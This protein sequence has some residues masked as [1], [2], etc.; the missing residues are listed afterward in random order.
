MPRGSKPLMGQQEKERPILDDVV[1]IPLQNLS[2]PAPLLPVPVAFPEVQFEDCSGVLNSELLCHHMHEMKASKS[3]GDG[4]LDAPPFPTSTAESDDVTFVSMTNGKRKGRKDSAQGLKRTKMDDDEVLKLPSTIC[5]FEMLFPSNTGSEA[6]KI[7]KKAKSGQAL[8]TAFTGVQIEAVP[9]REEDSL[10]QKYLQLCTAGDEVA[11]SLP[12]VDT[13]KVPFDREPHRFTNGRWLESM[14]VLCGGI[15]GTN[16][17]YVLEVSAEVRV[18]SG[19]EGKST[20]SGDRLLLELHLSLDLKLSMLR[21]TA[22]ASPP[23]LAD[24]LHRLLRFCYPNDEDERQIRSHDDLTASLIYSLLPCSRLPV[25]D[26]LQPSQLSPSLFP[27]QKRSVNFLLGREGKKITGQ[28]EDGESI[29]EALDGIMTHVGSQQLGLWWQRIE[30]GLF[31]NPLLGK[32]TRHAKETQLDQIQ[33]GILAEEMGLGKT[34]EVLALI[35]LNRDENRSTLP[36]HYDIEHELDISPTKTTLIVAPETLRQQWL[37]EIAL[38]APDLRTFSYLGHAEASKMVPQGM[39]WREYSRTFDIMVASF[40]TLR[41]EINVARKAPDRSRRF[42][43]KY[44][45]PRSLLIQLSFHRIVMD[46]VQLVGQAAA[47]ETVSLIDRHYSLAVSG[48]PIKT[49]N[50][51]KSLFHFL[52]VLTPATRRHWERLQ[53][54]ALLPSL[55]SCFAMLATRHTKA[56]VRQEMTLPL[57]TRILVPVT[58]TAI[59]SAF[60]RDISTRIYQGAGIDPL[61]F[62]SNKEILLHLQNQFQGDYTKLQ[63]SLVSLRQA[64]THPQI[65]GSHARGSNYSGQV[66]AT[67]NTIRSMEEVLTIMIEGTKADQALLWQHLVRKQINRAVLLLQDKNNDAR[68]DIAKAML[69]AVAG[70]II[71]KVDGVKEDYR[72]AAYIGPLYRFTKSEADADR[73]EQRDDDHQLLLDEGDEMEQLDTIPQRSETQADREKDHDLAERRI[74]KQRHLLNLGNRWRLFTEQLHRAH[75][76]EGNTYFQ[77]GEARKAQEAITL[78]NGRTVPAQDTKSKKPETDSET[79]KTPKDVIESAEVMRLKK[80]EDEAYDQAEKARQELLRLSRKGVESA[81]ASLDR[82]SAL[83]FKWEEL[84]CEVEFGQSGIYTEILFDRINETQDLLN[85]QTEV[86]VKWRSRILER[87]R[88][89]I[90]RDVSAEDENDDQYQ[91]NLDAQSEAEVLTEMYRVL[92]NEREFF[93]AGIRVE[94]STSKPALFVELERHSKTQKRLNFLQLSNPDDENVLRQLKNAPT[95]QQN[96]VMN[97]QLN[98]FQTLEKEKEEYVY[99]GDDQHTRDAPGEEEGGEGGGVASMRH[100]GKRRRVETEKSEIK[101][102]PSMALESIL[103]ALRECQQNKDGEEELALVQMAISKLRPLIA[104]QKVKC[105]KLK[106][107]HLS[108]M[109]VFNARSSYFKHMQQLSDDVGDIETSDIRKDMAALE[110]DEV[111]LKGKIDVAAGRLRYL[112]AIEEEEGGGRDDDKLGRPQEEGSGG[113]TCVICTDPLVKAVIFNT[114]G[115][116]TCENCFKSWTS[117][118]G[119]CPM[120]KTKVSPKEVYQVTYGSNGKGQKRQVHVPQVEKRK[121]QVER[122]NVITDDLVQSI[123]IMP[124]QSALGSKLDLLTRH[125]LY[126]EESRPGT[127]SLIFTAFSRGI[128][129]VGDALRLNNIKYVTLDQGGQKGGRIIDTFK[130]SPTVNVLLLHSEAQSSGLNLTCAENVFLLEPLVNHSIELQAIGRVHRIGQTM[131]TKVYIYQVNDTVEE[132]VIHLASGRG[133]SLVTRE[134]SIS[135]ELKDSAEW[136][137]KTQ[138]EIGSRGN[139]AKQKEGEFVAS[140]EEVFHCLFDEEEEEADEGEGRGR[141]ADQVISSPLKEEDEQRNKM[142]KER[143]EAIE[144]RQAMASIEKERDQQ[145]RR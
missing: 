56:Q 139:A 12:I 126:I 69:S 72:R 145:H 127:K 17:P 37:E 14:A 144:R 9:N 6:A 25:L 32:V 77:M 108:F 20:T 115:H 41:K 36:S 27:F 44:E 68:L 125:L 71:E 123:A 1:I 101:L 19:L 61:E 33:G 140:I 107:E 57:Q 93:I 134:N 86:L 80:C 38:H 34:V 97:L 110:Q 79:S 138:E 49:I 131:E 96:E 52:R 7:L 102:D 26:G 92:L 18:G 130:N 132:R 66:L 88:K 2:R 62:T 98:H 105:D 70:M 13:D 104:A 46:E 58:F 111:A 55:A 103:K 141:E 78:V 91:E 133:Q 113:R 99:K 100:T 135:K 73:R 112:S 28:A 39:D 48:T 119:I 87:L 118:R 3:A 143:I 81:L 83:D 16:T 142:R 65:A 50:D 47:A 124:I 106:R 51:L 60:Y 45:R 128:T 82:S 40:D 117:K 11:L 129:L 94:G 121:R 137:A 90:S 114:C 22:S 21:P 23:W 89:P 76:F 74:Y 30:D 67:S 31:Y 42:E 5:C 85:R 53:T 29:V 95:E 109:A 84:L 35:L 116:S 122:Y 136:I 63:H 75:H 24:H 10:L 120:C 54:P 59:E 43:R 4:A 64:C 15:V 8:L